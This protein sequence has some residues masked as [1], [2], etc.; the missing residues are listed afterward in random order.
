[1]ADQ[2]ESTDI[3][4]LGNAVPQIEGNDGPAEE[5]IASIVDMGFSREEALNA[6]S[7]SD[8]D[9]AK[10]I[11][12]IF[13]HSPAV[14]AAT[15]DPGHIEDADLARAMAN[16]L[17]TGDGEMQRGFY[18]P[19][20]PQR[21]FSESPSKALIP[22]SGTE[23]YED[24]QWGTISL[25]GN[26]AQLVRAREI[27]EPPL[28]VP[29]VE[30]PY[31]APLLVI[32]HCIPLAR[33][34]LLDGGKSLLSDYGFDPNW[35][36]GV[37]I[38]TTDSGE[39]L[40][41][42]SMPRFVA[43]SQRLM[44]FLDGLS[45]RPYADIRNFVIRGA[46]PQLSQELAE[47][48]SDDSGVGKLFK[49]LSSYWGPSSFYSNAFFT[50]VHVA[51]EDE[52]S[53]SPTVFSNLVCDATVA[54]ADSLYDLIDDMIWPPHQSPG[55]YLQ[56][57]SNILQLTVKRDDGESGA[58][59]DISTV[60]YP[61]KYSEEG[62]TFVRQ[63]KEMSDSMRKEIISKIKK[64]GEM[65]V[66]GDSD[67]SKLLQITVE[68]LGSQSDE[69][70]LNTQTA[71]ALRDIINI[72]K[73]YENN[74]SSISNEIETIQKDIKM[75][76]KLFNGPVDK[77]LFN[78]YFPGQTPPEII[79]YYLKGVII[80]PTEYCFY[81]DGSFED[82]TDPLLI[83]MEEA[84]SAEGSWWK[85]VQTYSGE[86]S[87]TKIS[88]ADVLDWAK[89]GSSIYKWQEVILVYAN[90]DALNKAHFKPIP[91]QLKTFLQQDREE[92]SKEIQRQENT[93]GDTIIESVEVE[94]DN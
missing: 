62:M 26:S 68:Y 48:T 31:I 93:T 21:T 24:N 46:P 3:Q 91:E 12:Y 88:E 25:G 28:L 36:N 2:P 70:P 85:V 57:I 63:V 13:N 23:Y 18:G 61:A 42:H 84:Q 89:A 30:T 35:W 64:R 94:M 54:M 78:K 82:V 81:S 71:E 59:V 83:D 86:P 5:S 29:A 73:K 1:M 11:E 69:D 6:L 56:R 33:A 9:V 8:N 39:A 75:L 10:A 60:W 72:Q 7:K 79:P 17:G 87:A 50:H 32:M 20:P 92:L 19:E 51:D 27:G 34:A 90:D 44:A 53:E 80:S 22:A 37:Y 76:S 67:G 58:G 41:V 66:F 40:P 4:A 55:N 45:K 47:D 43:E 52:Q 65:T 49:A 14:T 15:G 38:E 16:S 77:D 74:K